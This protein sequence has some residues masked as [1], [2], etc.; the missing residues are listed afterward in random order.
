MPRFAPN[1]KIFA[2]FFFFVTV[3]V[4]IMSVWKPYLNA[5]AQMFFIAIP[6]LSFL[7]RELWLVRHV[8][9][10]VFNLG[11]RSVV[12]MVS[13]FEFS[14]NFKENSEPCSMHKSD[15]WIFFK[16]CDF[17]G[18]WKFKKNFRPDCLLFWGA[19]PNDVTQK[20]QNHTFPDPCNF[21]LVQ[22]PN[23]LRF[24]QIQWN[25]LSSRDLASVE[26]HSDKFDGCCE[27]LLLPSL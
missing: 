4:T 19:F 25:N 12:V 10:K 26:W 2:T 21:H 1:R 8:E 23:F 20:N 6:T 13:D 16:N 14:R 3:F 11:M 22:R 27:F 17:N 15:R 7:A 5:F 9:K 18:S 24:L